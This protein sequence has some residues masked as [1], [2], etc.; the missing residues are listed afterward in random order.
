MDVRCPLGDNVDDDHG[1]TL[2]QVARTF[3]GEGATATR[4]VLVGRTDQFDG[5]PQLRPAHLLHHPDLIDVE[6]DKI[7]HGRERW[8]RWRPDLSDN[9]SIG[10][11]WLCA[12]LECAHIDLHAAPKRDKRHGE[13]LGRQLV[14][15]QLGG[16]RRRPGTVNPFPWS[17]QAQRWM[18]M[19]E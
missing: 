13:V 8:L 4:P 16:N 15:I 3:N 14:L 5:R 6:G 18:E 17:F 9:P 10:A 7:Y 19:V 11:F 12:S 1:N 2:L